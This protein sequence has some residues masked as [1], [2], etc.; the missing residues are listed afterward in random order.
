MGN[1]YALITPGGE[2]SWY[3]PGAASAVESMVSGTFAPSALD[4]A[5]VAPARVPGRG[6]LKVIASDIGLLFPE[7]FEP[8]P[9]AGAVL[10]ILS[11]GWLDQEWRGSVAIAEYAADPATGEVLWPC[12]MS[13]RWA[14]MVE[15][16][17]RRARDEVSR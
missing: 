3:P 13:P 12:E 1:A 2:L 17:V 4:T 14:H 9:L 16:A 11:A 15:A 7:R 8:N 5:T 6:P 10:R